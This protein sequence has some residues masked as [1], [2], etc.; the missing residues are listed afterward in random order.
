VTEEIIP[1]GYKRLISG[2]SQTRTF[3]FQ[4]VAMRYGKEL[5]LNLFGG[6]L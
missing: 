1:Q 6:L 2:V 4:I 3:N 5:Q